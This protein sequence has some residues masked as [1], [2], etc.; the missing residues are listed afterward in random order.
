MG[1]VR[2]DVHNLGR[3]RRI[4]A[5]VRLDLPDVS[6]E[7]RAGGGRSDGTISGKLP[8]GAV[9]T[10]PVEGREVSV[11]FGAGRVFDIRRVSAGVGGEA[12]ALFLERR[13]VPDLARV[14]EKF[15][16]QSDVGFVVGPAGHVETRLWRRLVVRADA[17]WLL[18][19]ADPIDLPRRQED[20]AYQT[21][22]RVGLG[23]GLQF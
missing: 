5:G 21:T 22:Y 18:Y 6:L 7:I 9:I 2:G 1:S 20:P 16:Q 8:N 14:E 11:T 13:V 17:A 12:G 19:V 15:P 3:A 4:D 23:L 10:R